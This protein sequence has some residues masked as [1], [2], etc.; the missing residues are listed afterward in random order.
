MINIF[1]PIVEDVERFSEFVSK[2]TENTTH[3]FVGIRASLKDKF[4]VSNKNIEIHVFDDKTKKEEM[5]NSLQKCEREK[6]ALLVIRRPISE[7]EFQSLTNTTADI[8]TL[9]PLQNKFVSWMKKVTKSIIRKVFAFSY[10]DDIS[11]V[12]F[13][14]YLHELISSCPNLSMASRID[15]Y[16][17]IEIAEIETSLKPAK[18]DFNKLKTSLVL[19]GGIFLFLASIAATACIF[20]FVKNIRAIYV[21]LVI[22]MLFFTFILFAISLVNFLRTLSVGTLEYNSGNEIELIKPVSIEEEKSLE[23]DKPR[24]PRTPRKKNNAEKNLTGEEVLVST[25]TEKPEAKRKTTAKSGSKSQTVKTA[26]SSGTKKSTAQTKEKAKSGT[27]SSSAK[28]VAKSSA[29]KTKSAQTGKNLNKSGK[30]SS[31]KQNSK[32]NK[33]KKE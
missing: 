28:S 17:G 31:T 25:S 1:V 21:V 11:A 26:K 30:T 27:K 13:S 12:Y 6:G 10:F 5:I 22:A 7:D 4:V 16:V 32:Q 23:E 24:K 14:E 9:K 20:V 3:I 15:K 19:A 29:T 18:K 33:T 2:H 8:A